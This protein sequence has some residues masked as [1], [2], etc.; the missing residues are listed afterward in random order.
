MAV[1]PESVLAKAR[2][3]LRVMRAAHGHEV[4]WLGRWE[5]ILDN[6]PDQVMRVLVGEGQEH[7]ELRQ[8]SPF[9]GVLTV[10]Q[11]RRVLQAFRRSQG[12]STT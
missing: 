3:N 2:A 7:G 4:P 5:A 12:R 8:N 1:D 9:A 11:R 10:R 6:G